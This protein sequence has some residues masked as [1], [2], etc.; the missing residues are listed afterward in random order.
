ML[1]DVDDGDPPPDH[2][3]ALLHNVWYEIEFHGNHV[4][5]EGDEVRFVPATTG[6]CAGA[7]AMASAYG[8]ALDALLRTSVQIPSD[9]PDGTEDARFLLCLAEVPTAPLPASFESFV[10]VRVV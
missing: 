6:S 2:E 9:A 4:L 8:G 7:A 5:H 3:L 1:L 10:S